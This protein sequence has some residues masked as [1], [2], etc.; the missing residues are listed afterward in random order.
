MAVAILHCITRNGR[1]SA[2]VPGEV[3]G[4][5]AQAPVCLVRICCGA[6]VA[7]ILLSAWRRGV[8][9]VTRELLGAMAHTSVCSVFVSGGSMPAAVHL[10]NAWGRHGT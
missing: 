6:M 7:A 10:S 3:I 4:A 8:T 5:V 9:V 1:N 2:V